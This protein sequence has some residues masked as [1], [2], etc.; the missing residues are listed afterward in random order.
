M[1]WKPD[2]KDHRLLILF[3]LNVQKTKI[4]AESKVLI[5]REEGI[6]EGRVYVWGWGNKRSSQLR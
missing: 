2:T 1:Q 5:R 3:K 6:F 4:P